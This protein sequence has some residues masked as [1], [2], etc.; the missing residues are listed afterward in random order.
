MRTGVPHSPSEQLPAS[1]IQGLE[2]ATQDRVSVWAR[3]SV[4]AVVL[5]IV[6]AGTFGV[7]GVHT[8]ESS[9]SES[10]WSVRLSYAGIARP[11]L[12]VPWQVTGHYLDIFE[13]QGFHPQPSHETRDAD[14]L[15]LTFEA[16]PSRDTLIV[17]YD[18]Y[19]QPSS[20]LG[21]RGAVS[22]LDH[23]RRL[24]TVAFTTRLLP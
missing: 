14:T 16:P 6:G 22:V 4:L 3:R 19:I 20:Q 13:T 24:A 10:G 1:S 11:G 15:Y 5:A 21:H 7:L 8:T 17:T 23:G 18:A 2:T 9:A 12:N